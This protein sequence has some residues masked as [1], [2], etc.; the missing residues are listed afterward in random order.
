[1]PETSHI[2]RHFTAAAPLRRVLR[3]IMVGGLAAAAPFPIA[4]A[5]G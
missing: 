4:L 1:M 2:E 5:T 3:A